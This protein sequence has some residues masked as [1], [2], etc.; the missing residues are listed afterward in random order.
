[1]NAPSLPAHIEHIVPPE[2][3]AVAHRNQATSLR[4]RA[5]SEL[6]STEREALNDAAVAHEA[7]A[8]RLTRCAELAREA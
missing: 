3:R 8:R 2:L 7:E 4:F 1:M 5:L 6:S